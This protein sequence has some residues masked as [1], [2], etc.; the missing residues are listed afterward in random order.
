VTAISK[1]RAGATAGGRKPQRSRRA[2]AGL[3]SAHEYLVTVD[4]IVR[5]QEPARQA[6]L[7]QAW[8]ISILTG[9]MNV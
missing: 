1:R 2:R 3:R 6:L 9:T 7:D 8:N 5:H 4:S